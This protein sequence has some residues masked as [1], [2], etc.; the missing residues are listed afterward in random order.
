MKKIISPLLFI[1]ICIL[2]ACEGPTGPEGPPGPQGPS[3][4]DGQDGFNI[5]GGVFEV[6]TDFTAA[7][8]Y[9]FLF[10]FPPEELEVFESDVVL[11]YM[12]WNVGEDSEGNPLDIW[13]LIPQTFYFD[14]GTLQYNYDYSYL[15]IQIY[16]DGPIDYSLLDEVWTQD[17]VFRVVVLPADIIPENAR[18]DIDYSNYDEVIRTFGLDDSNVK[19]F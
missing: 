15:D 19:R 9:S 16:L 3:G 10:V 12:L 17:Q 14:E 11:V 8:D 7:N 4:Q 13:R 6:V 18:M 1:F 2:S 5:V